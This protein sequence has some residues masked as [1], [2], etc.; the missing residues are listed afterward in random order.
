MAEAGCYNISL[1]VESF[2]DMTTQLA[3]RKQNSDLIR[4]VVERCKRQGVELSC[5]L[6]MGFPGQS[7]EDIR[8]DIHLS[9]NFSFDFIH[10][11]VFNPIPGLGAQNNN[12]A[13]D[14]AAQ[15]DLSCCFPD[16]RILERMQRLAYLS[17]CF[18]PSILRFIVRR[19]LSFKLPIAMLKKAYYYIF[20]KQHI[21]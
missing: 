12:K 9:R 15:K 6:I 5:H 17:L 7:L 2:K 18:K 21:H 13:G 10:Y 8:Y 19:L 16:R 20:G 1:G 11:N 14:A 3:G 4:A